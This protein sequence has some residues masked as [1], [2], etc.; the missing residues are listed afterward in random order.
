MAAA[1]VGGQTLYAAC[2]QHLWHLTAVDHEHAAQHPQV[3]MALP[4]LALLLQVVKM[5]RRSGVHRG[6]LLRKG[7]GERMR[8]LAWTRRS[9]QHHCSSAG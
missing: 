1:Y 9:E 5:M 6:S 3:A 8:S 4:G 2:C 7:R